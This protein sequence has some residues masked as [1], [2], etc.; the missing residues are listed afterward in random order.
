M[1]GRAIVGDLE[2]LPLSNRVMLYV[3]I[4]CTVNLATNKWTT[5]SMSTGHIWAVYC[6]L[7]GATSSEQQARM[8]SRSELTMRESMTVPG[9]LEARRTLT[10]ACRCCREKHVS[11]SRPDTEA[12]PAESIT[13]AMATP[14]SV[15]ILITVAMV[16]ARAVYPEPDLSCLSLFYGRWCKPGGVGGD[17]GTTRMVSVGEGEL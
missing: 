12:R 17:P 15:G 2:P 14:A 4:K 11:G 9:R 13:I 5:S 3:W 8:Q 1:Y 7:P 6:R 16:T 10:V